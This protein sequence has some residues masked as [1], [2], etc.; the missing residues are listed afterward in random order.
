MKKILLLLF[1]M[2]FSSTSISEWTEMNENMEGTVLFLDLD[3][4]RKDDQFVFY[5]VMSD[6]TNLKCIF[7]LPLRT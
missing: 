4:I 5:W 2:M 6:Y 1:T 3:R 7:C